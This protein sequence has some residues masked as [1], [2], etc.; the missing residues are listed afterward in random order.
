M[1]DTSPRQNNYQL[2][3]SNEEQE[4][5]SGLS[6]FTAEN[7]SAFVK[8]FQ[9]CFLAWIQTALGTWYQFQVDKPLVYF[10]LLEATQDQLFVFIFHLH[11]FL[12][13]LFSCLVIL[14]PSFRF[15]VILASVPCSFK[16]CS[17]HAHVI[18]FFATPASLIC[19]PHVIQTFCS[20]LTIL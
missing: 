1:L 4:W 19:I 12:F 16:H 2:P 20:I 11:E 10:W 17:P 5:M 15:T 7:S 13:Y 8:A 18:L 14:F 6:Q 3:V 9:L